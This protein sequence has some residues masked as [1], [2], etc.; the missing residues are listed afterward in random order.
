MKEFLGKTVSIV[1]VDGLKLSG[2]V[3]E[4][5]GPDETDSHEVE[6]GI[7]YAGGIRM[8]AQSEIKSITANSAT[9]GEV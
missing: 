1:T 8:I 9:F 3:V 4:L 5:A 7:N 6:I 2:K